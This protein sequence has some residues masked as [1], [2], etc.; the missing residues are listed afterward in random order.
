MI[1]SENDAIEQAY[2][3]FLIMK[4]NFNNPYG[5]PKMYGVI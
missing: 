3:H 5:L 4:I 2:L 1:Q